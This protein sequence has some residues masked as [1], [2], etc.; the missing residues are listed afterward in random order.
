MKKYN[1]IPPVF[2]I[3][4]T[5][6]LPPQAIEI[7]ESVLGAL[8]LEKNA[9]ERISEILKPEMFYKTEHQKVFQSIQQLYHLNTAID[10]HTVSEALKRSGCLDEI[11]GLY[12]LM[13]LTS[14]ISVNIETHALIIYQKWIARELIDISIK[15]QSEAFNENVDVADIISGME[16]K[17]TEITDQSDDEDIPFVDVVS[18][19]KAH[20]IEVQ[21]LREQGKDVALSTPLKA[22]NE[23][24]SGGF[25]PP[26]LI[27][28]AARPA[29]GKTQV[30]IEFTEHFLNNGRGA[31]F[32]LEMKKTQI[33]LRMVAKG[34][35]SMDNIK[36]GRMTH[37]EWMI[38]DRRFG[39]LSNYDLSIFDKVRTIDGIVRRCRKLKRQN[40]LNFVAIDYL[41]LIRT[42]EKFGTRDLEVGYITNQLKSLAIELDV[43]VIL[44]CQLNRDLEKR[45]D[46]RPQLSDLRE[47][48]NI[49]QDADMVIFIH[50]PC[51]YDENA[52]DE[53]GVS[54]KHRGELII[55][56]NRDGSTGSV[57]FEHD[58]QFKRIW[59]Y[60]QEDYLRRHSGYLPPLGEKKHAWERDNAPF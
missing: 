5:G 8:M 41:Q 55:A 2:T 60:N 7:E 20:M 9:F 49:E 21:K 52:T 51:Y 10:M 57:S 59:D 19:T 45:G 4:E 54:Y 36:Q 28:L 38:A 40:R 1:N 24:L 56:K 34:G 11:G 42:N 12:F 46:K 37:E 26:E 30:S 13:E 31:F 44:L 14:K 35:I 16:R 27:I 23:K 25:R 43:P 15:T 29:M 3:S 18:E 50:R 39:E 53:D 6:K 22:L 48:G 32:S 58:E 33:L 47:S 17:L